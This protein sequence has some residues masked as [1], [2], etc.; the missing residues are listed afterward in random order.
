MSDTEM[1]H[2]CDLPTGRAGYSEDSLYVNLAEDEFGP[3]CESCFDVLVQSFEV[4]ICKKTTPVRVSEVDSTDKPTLESMEAVF[5]QNEDSCGRAGD[6][7]QE[8]KI[9]TH[10]AGDGIYYTIETE[11][12][13]FDCVEELSELIAKIK[14]FIEGK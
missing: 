12:W 2:V 13:A 3:L 1:C 4:C 9:S 6:W 14:H 8:L 11:R 10:D 5:T 7:T